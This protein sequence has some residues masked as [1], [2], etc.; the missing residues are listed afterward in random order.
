[1]RRLLPPHALTPMLRS[2]FGRLTAL[3]A[4]AAGL[5]T[6]AGFFVLAPGLDLAGLFLAD[7]VAIILAAAVLLG[8]Q[9]VAQSHW[10]RV[11]GRAGGWPYSLV[12]LVSAAVVLALG[13]RPGSPGATDAGVTWTYR[14]VL[15]PLNATVFSLLAFFVASAA[16]RTLRLRTRE[17]FVVLVAALIVLLGQVPIGFQ[18]WPDL[19]FVKE[20]LL[21]VPVSGAF[22]GML[23]GVA[24]GT[25]GAGL[26]ILLTQDRPYNQEH[27][28]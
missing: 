27:T 20:W 7:W 13:L 3:V 16:Y 12:L 11:A 28:R 24:L 25:V 22:R 14:Y 26:R 9:N 19:P 23:L 21:E 4:F 8:L 17:S 18:I 2:L 10:K 1:M 6:L 5:V 15:S